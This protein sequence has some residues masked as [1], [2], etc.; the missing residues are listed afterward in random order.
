VSID[1]QGELAQ[2]LEASIP[3]RRGILD[4]DPE[5]RALT[6]LAKRNRKQRPRTPLDALQ[7]VVDA[8]RELTNGTYGALAVTGTDD[9]VEG[10]AVSGMDERALASLKGPPQGHGPLGT[11]RMDGLPV[12][13][14]D[15]GEHEKAFGFPPKH[16]GMK[17]LLGV[18]IFCGS[19]VRG[20]LYVTDRRNGKEFTDEDQQILRVL[21]RHAAL[22]IEAS[23]Y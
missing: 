8:A 7:H 1:V 16:P 23:W 15:V 20:A 5:Y 14:R 17:E 9:Y 21:S 19:T 22:I 18:P 11:M 3:E 10:F 12:H 6:L 13:L 4:R 2:K